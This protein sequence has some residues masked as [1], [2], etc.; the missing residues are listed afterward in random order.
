MHKIKNNAQVIDISS[1]IRSRV[2]R[3]EL[4]QAI[5]NDE[6]CLHYQPRFKTGNGKAMVLEALVRWNHP[7]RGL[8][9]P[10]KFIPLAETSG[11]IHQLGVWVIKRACQDIHQLY[12]TQTLG[13]NMRISINM[14]ILQCEYPHTA[15][16]IQKIIQNTGLT[17]NSFEFELTESIAIDDEDSVIQFCQTLADGGAQISLDDFGTGQ[18]SLMHLSRIPANTVKI[19]KHFVANLSESNRDTMLIKHIISMSHDL[20]AKVVAEGIEDEEQLQMLTSMGCDEL[21]GYYMCKPLARDALSAWTM[22]M[23]WLH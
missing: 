8:L 13:K 1:K 4:Q 17:L 16:K 20:G 5:L 7:T 22:N 11:L 23:G 2:R 15:K 3:E 9:L 12:E 6:L 14:S 10:E 18:S 21:Q 19:D